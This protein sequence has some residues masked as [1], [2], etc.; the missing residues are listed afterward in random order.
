MSELSQFEFIKPGKKISKRHLVEY[1]PE[2][3]DCVEG[4]KRIN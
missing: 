2:A 1:C 3:L 4:G